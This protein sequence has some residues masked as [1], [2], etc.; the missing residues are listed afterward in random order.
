MKRFAFLF[1]A[2]G[3]IGASAQA[4]VITQWNFN[5]VTP[6]NNSATG[7]FTP[8]I[9]AG[10]VSAVGGVNGTTFVSGFSDG[11]SS[12]PATDDNSAWQTTTYA[13]SAPNKSAGI[14]AL[15]STAGFENIIVTF[16]SRHSNTASRY[17]QFQYTTDGATWVDFGTTLDHNAG[18]AWF[19]V[20][21]FNLSSVSGV[22]NNAAFGFR[23]VAAF[24]PAGSYVASNDGSNFGAAGTIRY[25]MLTVSGSVVPEPATMA[26]LGLG[27][28]A[29]IRRKRK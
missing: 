2:V 14:Q 8:N 17:L 9:G 21:T 7:T 26:A 18:A 20:D 22:N 23:V 16:D 19:N 13:T 11:G 27:T 24:G 4:V 6:D 25:D 1:L 5:S 12:D 10:S 15:T 28:L 3:V 29:L